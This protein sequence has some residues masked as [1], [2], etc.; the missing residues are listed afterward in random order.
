MTQD[1]AAFV[2]FRGKAGD[3]NPFGMT[4]A[5]LLGNALAG[6]F[7]RKPIAV[8]EPQSPSTDHRWADELQAARSGLRELAHTYETIFMS[9]RVPITTMGRCACALATLPMVTRFRR[10]ATIV[11]FDAHGDSNTPATSTSGYLGGM[12]LTGAAGIWETGLGDGLDLSHVVLVGARDIDPA[13]R[14]LMQTA[15]IRHLPPGPNLI[16]ELEEA[17]GNSALYVH[18]DCDVL[19]PGI[20]PTEFTAEHGLSL[21]IFKE[22]CALLAKCELVGLEVAEFESVW[23]K[24]G[25]QA[26]P[27]PLVDALV[28]LVEKIIAS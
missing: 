18:V 21:E 16:A 26:S 7:N 4:G 17:V 5:V 12:V 9:A 15:G 25:A 27:Q 8:G 13:E 10:D 11:W 3:R 6:R 22:A 1:R 28:P 2:Q 20:V 19:D 14:E 24:S 23:P